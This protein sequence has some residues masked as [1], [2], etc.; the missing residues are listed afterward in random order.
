MPPAMFNTT[1]NRSM[2][3]NNDE[4][5]TQYLDVQKGI[6]NACLDYNLATGRLASMIANGSDT[7]F[8]WSYLPGSDLGR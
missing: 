4:S 2:S 7:P 8:A 1:I 5:Y 6:K 3:E